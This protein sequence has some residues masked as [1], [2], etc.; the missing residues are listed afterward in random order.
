MR[1]AAAAIVLSAFAASG[2]ALTLPSGLDKA[3]LDELN[4]NRPAIN[5]K[6]QKSVPSS[7][8]INVKE[9][10]SSGTCIIPNPF[11]GCI[12]HGSASYSVELQKLSNLSEL[13]YAGLDLA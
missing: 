3:I 4:K 11:G 12:C 1:I 2:R 10:G 6:I 8:D 9:D 5:S 13:D 7:A